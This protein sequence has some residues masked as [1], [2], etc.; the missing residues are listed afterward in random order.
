MRFRQSVT[1]PGKHTLRITMVD[2]TLVVEKIVISN[3]PAPPSYFGPPAAVPV[4]DNSSR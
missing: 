1:E 3:A 4:G 2:P